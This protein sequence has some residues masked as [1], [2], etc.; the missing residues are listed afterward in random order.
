MNK[1]TT[2]QLVALRAYADWAGK[3]WKTQ[4]RRDWSRS[5]SQWNGEYAHLQQLRNQFGPS[6]LATFTFTKESATC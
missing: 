5:G 1:P 6:W 4:L 3:N 2:E